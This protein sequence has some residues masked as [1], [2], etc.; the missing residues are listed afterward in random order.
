MTEDWTR[1]DAIAVLAMPLNRL[2]YRDYDIRRGGDGLGFEDQTY[3]NGTEQDI[4]R[5]RAYDV[6]VLGPALRVV[7]EAG[8]RALADDLRINRYITALYSGDSDEIR[9]VEAELRAEEAPDPPPDPNA[10]TPE[11]VADAMIADLHARYPS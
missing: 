3:S 10:M 11:Q 1:Q 2:M 4:A 5:E 7:L 8:I 6:L 9:A